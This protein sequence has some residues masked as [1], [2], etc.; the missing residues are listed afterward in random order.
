MG[1]LFTPFFNTAVAIS[2]RLK[3]PIK[4]R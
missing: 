4:W 2:N 1:D 3:P